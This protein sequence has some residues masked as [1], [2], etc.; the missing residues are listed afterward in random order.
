MKNEI[1]MGVIVALI[2]IAY[3]I[4]PASGALNAIPSGGTVFIGERGLDITAS[5]A[6]P[7][8]LLYYYGAGNNVTSGVQPEKTSVD[9]PRLFYVDP[10]VFGGKTG[11]WYIAGKN[12][13]A[14]IITDP[15]LSISLYDETQ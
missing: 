3:M 14:F 2:S 8:S 6:T 4:L 10:A 9:D 15:N 13:P 11:A 1:Q 7:G 12:D 5:G